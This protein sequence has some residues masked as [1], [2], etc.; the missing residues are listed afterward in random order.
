MDSAVVVVVVIVVVVEVVVDVVVCSVVEVLSKFSFSVVFMRNLKQIY[1]YLDRTLVY[2]ITSLLPSLLSWHPQK[3]T[4]LH[5][6]LNGPCLRL[7]L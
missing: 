1:Q 5:I 2:T 3:N 7:Y 6:C 4:F